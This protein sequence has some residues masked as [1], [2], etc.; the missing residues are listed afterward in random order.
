MKKFACMMLAL[1]LCL[2]SVAALAESTPSKTMA[3]LQW[4]DAD[5]EKDPEDSG[6]YIRIVTAD[7]KDYQERVEIC[8]EEIA[9]LAVAENVEAYFG[10][11]MDLKAIVGADKLNV[12][13]YVP[14]IAGGY[15]TA[16]GEVTTKIWLATPYEV[17]EKVAVMIGMVTEN[18]DGTRM[19]SWKAFAGVGIAPESE[20]AVAGIQ[21][22]LDPE[23]V[24]AIQEGVALLAI[25]SD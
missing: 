5:A 22:E 24:L 3:D 18:T 6:F 12:Y 10:E 2:T 17:D 13:E 4:I 7:E 8:T 14:I 20:V 19:V 11:E 9:K 25:V 15:D 1:L 16:Y 23:T 21:T